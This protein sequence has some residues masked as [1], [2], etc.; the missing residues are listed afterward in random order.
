MRSRTALPSASA[1]LETA[2]APGAWS[3]QPIVWLGAGILAASIIGCV[4]MIVLAWRYPD[5]PVP[6]NG[7]QAMKVPVERAAAGSPA[8]EPQR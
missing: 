7:A 3:R 6:T 2:P 8:P 1:D 4:T 5:V